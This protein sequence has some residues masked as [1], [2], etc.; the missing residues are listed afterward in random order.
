MKKE[1]KKGGTHLNLPELYKKVRG[2][3]KK[4]LVGGKFGRPL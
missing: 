4:L 2:R 1:M 3:G